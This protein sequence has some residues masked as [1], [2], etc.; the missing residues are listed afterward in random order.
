MYVSLLPGGG[1][2]RRLRIE[3]E[4]ALY[5]VMSRGNYR[6]PIFEE[7]GAK[8]AFLRCLLQASERAGWVLHAF[9]I[10]S[11]HYH[12][13]LGTPRGNLSAGMQW[14]QSTF[15]TRFNRFRAENGHVFHGR[16]KA[17]LVE[18]V[19]ELAKVC[20][21]IHLNPVRAGLTPV[22][23]LG[24]YR[25]SSYALG[26]VRKYD[27][28]RIEVETFLSGAGGLAN[29]SAGWR[30]YGQYLSWLAAADAEQ[31]RLRFE[32]MSRG[33]V[34]GSADFRRD[35]AASARAKLGSPQHA[36]AETR[37]AKHALWE[38]LCS[39]MLERLGKKYDEAKKEKKSAAWKIAVAAQMKSCC[40]VKN[41]WLADRLHMGD[42]DGVSRYVGELAKGQRPSA[43]FLI[44]K[45]TD[46]RV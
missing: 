36:R 22:E 27:G 38:S 40:T 4:G 43:S 31:K 33:W 32:A 37:D 21:Y 44:K 14:L 13:A 39:R 20:H 24:L 29:T 23:R 6:S 34:I 26:R 45:I 42:P 30:S 18:S 28:P 5:H 35:M 2:A 12:I 25:Y 17:L 10:M 41:P 9:V 19:S 1:M 3:F 7:P 15:A 11:N 8:A 16:Y 46:I